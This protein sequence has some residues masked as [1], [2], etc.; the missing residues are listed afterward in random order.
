MGDRQLSVCRLAYKLAISTII[1]VYEIVS[2]H[3]SMKKVSTR[4]TPK[5]LKPIQC[6]NRVGCC[7]ELLQES[8]VNP[9]NY[10]H[11][12]VTSDEIW[13]SYYDSFSEEEAKDWKKSDDEAST[14]L[15]RTRP[16]EKIMMVIFWDKYGNLLTE[17]LPGGLRSAV[18]VMH[19]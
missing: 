16:V 18:P 14:R 3:L 4:W 10:F 12:I 9:D 8:E 17:Y 15:R 1:T 7:E 13:V 2:N 6:A 11:C 19:Q 5:L